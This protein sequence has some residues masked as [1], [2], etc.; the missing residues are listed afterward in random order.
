[1]EK[2]VK[3]INS[4]QM[5]HLLFFGVVVSEDSSFAHRLPWHSLDEVLHWTPQWRNS[6]Y[7]T[8]R[9]FSFQKTEW[10]QWFLIL[11]RA[12]SC[13]NIPSLS[14]KYGVATRRRSEKIRKMVLG[15][16]AYFVRGSM[17]LNSLRAVWL[18][19]K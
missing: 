3:G 2:T 18:S 19:F 4:D 12:N 13:L 10:L 7:H 15:S 8:I 17:L 1:M 9:Y 6:A 16:V 14:T 11:S 5:L